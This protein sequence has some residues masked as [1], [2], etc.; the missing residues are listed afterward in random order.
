MKHLILILFLFVCQKGY[1]QTGLLP[2]DA[3][4][5]V[6]YSDSG[7]PNKSKSEIFK[8][9]QNW[10]SKT[11]GNYENAVTFEDPQLGKLILTS[12]APV[13]GIAYEYVRFDLTI[14]CKEEQYNVRI[15]K[16]DGIS[17]THSP[18]RLGAKDNNAI[19]E[20]EVAVKT[21]Q[22]KKKRAEAE[23]ALRNAKA[24][25]ESINNAMYKL[26]SDLKLSLTQPA[27]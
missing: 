15:D 23:A 8:Q 1:S 22:S 11:F 25:M 16:L 17:T 27:E 14:E 5:N 6:F 18:S 3:E 9:A 7:K 13:S 10:I 24:D 21:E 12:Y 26:M 20:K 2:L 19:M 4:K